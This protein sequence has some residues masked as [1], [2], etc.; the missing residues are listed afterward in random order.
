MKRRRPRLGCVLVTLLAVP[1]LSCCSGIFLS[2]LPAP[3]PMPP[4]AVAP[5]FDAE[6]QHARGRGFV[7]VRDERWEHAR[8]EDADELLLDLAASTCVAA[9][10]ATCLTARR[11]TT[12]P[13]P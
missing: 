10:G 1:A 13:I 7:I 9:I 4:E 3:E 5:S 8:P 11:T 6:L 2:T 12:D